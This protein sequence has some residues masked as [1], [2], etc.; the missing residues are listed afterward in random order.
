MTDKQKL[1]I[2]PG[3]SG[4]EMLWE[5]QLTNLKDI[6]DPKVL[7]ITNQNTVEKMAEEVVKRTP[8]KFILAGHSLG[9]WVAQ[10]I[11][12]KYPE[13]IRRLILMAT[14]TGASSSDFIDFLKQSL[15]RIENNEREALL[16]EIRPNLIYQARTNKKELFALIKS[17]QSQF[18]TEGLINQTLAEINSPDTASL[19]HKINC[20]TLIIH[21]REDSFFSLEEQELMRD[22][23]PQAKLTIIE[24]CG[25]MLS[26][27]RPQAV[28]DLIRL[29]VQS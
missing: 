13:R 10:S 7:V 20:P 26:I 5:H 22:K 14:W 9:G 8:E 25:H 21:G 27:E 2:L 1:I 12:S 11:A 23:I 18:P 4:N 19:L 15:K 16:D 3:W 29:W 17:A 6:C 28:T 24:E